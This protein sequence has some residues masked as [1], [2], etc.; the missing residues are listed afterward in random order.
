MSRIEPVRRVTLDLFNEADA[1]TPSDAGS[2]AVANSG[3][4]DNHKRGTVAS[5][6]QDKIAEGSAPM[7]ATIG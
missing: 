3:L 5:F 7:C 2:V 4:R 6:L 1:L